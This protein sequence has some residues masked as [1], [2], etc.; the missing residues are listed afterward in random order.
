MSSR[1]ITLPKIVSEKNPY[2]HAHL[3]YIGRKSTKFKM[4]PMKDVEG[5]A[6]TRIW[7]NKVSIGDKSVENSRT[8]IPKPHAHF[9]IRGRNSTIFQVIS[10]TDVG[11]LAET[12]SRTD[13]RTDGR[14][15]ER[16]DE[17]G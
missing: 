3:H 5:V 4:N 1:A 17:R 11:G 9:H 15:G 7:M 16:T 14:T 12:T 6:E 10:M 8:K 2:T 13:G